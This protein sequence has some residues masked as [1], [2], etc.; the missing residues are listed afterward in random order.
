MHITK[1]R[2]NKGGKGEEKKKGEIKIIFFSG[3]KAVPGGDNAG[4][5][6]PALELDN[7]L[8]R[9]VVIDEL[10]LTNVTAGKK[11]PC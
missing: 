3:K 6:D 2:E 8:A 9:P 4:L 5:V 1:E 7:D 10:E 11:A